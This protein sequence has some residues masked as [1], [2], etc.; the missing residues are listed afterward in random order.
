MIATL[1]TPMLFRPLD[2]GI[3]NILQIDPPSGQLSA[4][5]AGLCKARAIS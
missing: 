4:Y 1:L 2:G 5:A 3:L